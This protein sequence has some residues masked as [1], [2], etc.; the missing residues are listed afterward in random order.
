[1]NENITTT[2]SKAELEMLEISRKEKAL[3]AEKKAAEEKLFMARVIENMKKDVETF[4][5]KKAAKEVSQWMEQFNYE[6]P[7]KFELKVKSNEKIFEATNGRYNTEKVVYE[8]VKVPYNSYTIIYKG[9]EIYLSIDW[10]D[11][12]DG[13]NSG[14]RMCIHG[15]P[16]GEADRQYKKPV[17]VIKKISEYIGKVERA[18]TIET[19]RMTLQEYAVEKIKVIYPE[20]TVEK[21]SYAVAGVYHGPRWAR[22]SSSTTE[23]VKATFPNGF[24]VNFSFSRLD[25]NAELSPENTKINVY[26][27][28]IASLDRMEIVNILKGLNKATV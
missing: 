13:Q 27:W 23:L 25:G 16:Y 24:V 18:K 5:V 3:A 11:D 7:G 22:R 14:Y 8:T 2:V 15:L 10:H 26:T 1:M 20:A 9:T 17:T 12:Y 6:A 21:F 28:D 4:K 19:I